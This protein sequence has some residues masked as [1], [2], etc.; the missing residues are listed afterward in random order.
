F[1][2]AATWGLMLGGRLVATHGEH[3]L[4]QALHRLLAR[5]GEPVVRKGVD[6]A[7]RLMGEHFVAGETIGQALANAARLEARGF[8]H[9]YEMR[10]EAALTDADAK[11]YV[12]A[13]EEAIHAIGGVSAGLGVHRG[14]GISIKLSALHPRYGR[15]QRERVLAELYPRLLG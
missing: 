10:G 12:A 3:G 1:V 9:S 7:M 15:A 4:G 13:Y 5:G 8:R 11:R 6:L 2:N 14:P